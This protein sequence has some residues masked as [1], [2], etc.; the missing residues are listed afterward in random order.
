MKEENEVLKFIV[1]ITSED[2]EATGELKNITKIKK[3]WQEKKKK[4][5]KKIFEKFFFGTIQVDPEI[6][7]TFKNY[8]E[9]FLI[10]GNI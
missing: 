5:K 1:E 10:Y 9:E 6:F 3:K 8:Y 2:I 7:G 4:I